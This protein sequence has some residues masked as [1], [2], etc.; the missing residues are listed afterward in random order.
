MSKN[1]GFD[2]D[3]VHVLRSHDEDEQREWFRKALA[4]L[5][6]VKTKEVIAIKPNFGSPLPSQ[7][8]AT[9]SLW[10]LEETVAYVRKKR[11]KP[12]LVEAPSHIHDY[13]QVMEVTGAAE[14]CQ[15]LG[16]EH[17]DAR[18]DTM[19]LRPLKHD[20]AKGLIYNVHIAA[21]SADGIIC[22]PKL[23]THNRTG[24]SLGMK[25]LMG[26]LSVPDRH[27]FHRRGV[28]EDVVELYKRL[29]HRIRGT[30]IDGIVAMEGHGPTNGQPVQ[31]NTIIG[32]RDLV[33][34]DAVGCMV[35]GY[36][37]EEIH[38]LHQAHDAGLGNMQPHWVMH[39]AT[40][41]LPVKPFRRPRP[42]N[43]IRTQVMTF[44]PLSAA[45]RL[46][47]M[48]VRG[49]TKPVLEPVALCSTCTECTTVCPT[50]AID[51]PL[52]LDY[53]A[54]IGCGLCIE[55]CPA[56]ALK[57]EGRT[58]KARRVLKELTGV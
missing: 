16:L 3:K 37:A 30:F 52:R 20:S 8:G 34:V 33:A 13:D 58:H 50:N 43:G 49:R 41:P 44:P 19:P 4:A 39:P 15:R 17:A 40:A 29:Q 24:V 35:M 57:P 25:G 45:L 28:E 26:L 38:H 5:V 14:L 10:M 32:G 36:E 42:D 48:G 7:T 27:A 47:Q 12:I 56:D 23:K 22:L 11:A 53:E 1:K 18:L 46:A 54:C 6:K 21:Q 9:T 31:M 51:A 55:V 2:P